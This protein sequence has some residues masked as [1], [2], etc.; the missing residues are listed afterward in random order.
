MALE[1]PG[2][3][4]IRLAAKPGGR[5]LPEISEQ[6]ARAGKPRKPPIRIENQDS[7]HARTRKQPS[8]QSH[9]PKWKAERDNKDISFLQTQELK[10]I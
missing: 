3:K 2:I 8:I 5:L 7:E 6:Q 10:K 4:G 9:R 1:R